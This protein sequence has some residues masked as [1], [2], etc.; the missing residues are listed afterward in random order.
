MLK[1][2]LVK[3]LNFLGKYKRIFIALLDQVFIKK[4][5]S[6]HGEDIFFINYI[7]KNN[8]VCNDY[9][10]IDIGANHPTDISN[11]FLLYKNGMTGIIIEPNLELIQLFKYFRKKDILYAIGA[12]KYSK[13]SKFFISKTPV[14]SSFNQNWRKTEMRK[15]YFMPIMTIDDALRNNLDKPIFLISIDVEG[16][17]KDVL[18]GAFETISKTLLICIEFDDLN[19]KIDYQSLLGPNF[20]PII[21]IGC[22]TIFENT[23]LT[24]LKNNNS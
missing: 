18:E 11:T 3:Y 1:L 22:N 8:I 17:N 9:I 16:L 10:Y 19:D 7:K 5:Y 13:M 14:L 2:F 12:G 6:Q 4:T 20:V 21:D 15:N 24:L 23:K